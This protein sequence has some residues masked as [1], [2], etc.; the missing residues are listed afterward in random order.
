MVVTSWCCREKTDQYPQHKTKVAVSAT[1]RNT[2]DIQYSE[3][4]TP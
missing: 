2:E 3:F 1:P 4:S